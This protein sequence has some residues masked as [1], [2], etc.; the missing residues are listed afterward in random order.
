MRTLGI[1]S[2]VLLACIAPAHAWDRDGHRAICYTALELTTESA[3][4]QIFTLLGIST[5]DQ[6][7]EACVWADHIATDRPATAAWHGIDIPKDARAIDLARD[8]KGPAS[9]IVAQIE[10]HAATLKSTAPKTDRAEALRFL[11]HLVGDLHQPINIGFTDQRGG[12]EI[13]GMFHGRPSNLHDVWDRGLLA[14]LVPAGRDGAKIIY[15]AS[16]WMGRL[17]GGEKKTPLEWANETLWITVAPPTGYLGN[18]GGDFFGERYIRQNRQVALEQIDKAGFR[19]GE[20]L[21]EA[22]K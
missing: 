6:F 8:C 7:A 2:F 1:A 11:A 21:N 4:K 22:L 13:S 5:E 3:R 18:P 10:K 9:C 17:N 14:T 16:A 19:L 15:D 12:R 20:M